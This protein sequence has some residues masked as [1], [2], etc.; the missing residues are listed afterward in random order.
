MKNIESIIIPCL[1]AP[2][3]DK[4]EQY[5]KKSRLLCFDEISTITLRTL[6][7]KQG[8]RDVV[9]LVCIA[10]SPKI[11]INIMPFVLLNF[12]FRDYPL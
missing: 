3:G 10:K 9:H 2:P 12:I 4:K 6:Q 11:G 8:K 5:D 7:K 1:Q